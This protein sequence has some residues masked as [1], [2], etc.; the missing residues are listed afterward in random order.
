MFDKE[1]LDEILRT[2]DVPSDKKDLS[3]KENLAW[4]SR[5]LGRMNFRH[6]N[7]Y[8]AVRLAKAGSKEN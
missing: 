7:Y 6:P 3:K 5:N 1:R 4:L 8:E 2:M